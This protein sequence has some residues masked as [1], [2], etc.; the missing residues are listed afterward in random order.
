VPPRPATPTDAPGL[1]RR[2]FLGLTIGAAS[3][4]LAGC[5]GSLTGSG[6]SGPEAGDLLVSND[7]R[8]RHSVAVTATPTGTAATGTAGERVVVGIA[9]GE[10][11]LRRAFVGEPGVYRVMARLLGRSPVRID[12]YEL[13]RGPEGSVDGPYVRATIGDGGTLALDAVATASTT[14]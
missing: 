2:R 9:P 5:L 13:D 14:E 12:D 6:G 3:G 11:V 10:P 7:D 4:A 1:G 8:E